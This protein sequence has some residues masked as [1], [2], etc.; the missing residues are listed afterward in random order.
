M[1]KVIVVGASSGIGAELVRLMIERGDR[2]AAVARR[3]DRLEELEG[4]LRFAHDVRRTEEIPAL[5][6]DICGQLGGLDMIVYAAGVMP[7]VGPEEFDTEKDLQMIDVN[8]A[9]AVAWLNQAAI[10]FQN[11]K[12]GT[13][14]GIGSVAG[15]RGRQGQ[16]VYNASKAA[17]KAYLEALRNRL[18]RQGV[19]VVTIKPGPTATEMTA[20]M[21]QS[22]M[23]P[24]RQA[25]ELILKKSPREGEHFLKPTH[26]IIFAIIRNIPSFILRRLKI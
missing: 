1:K 7:E 12:A 15:E 9:G 6:Q 17:F 2:V 3:G 25:A 13:I 20:H 23:M 18:S 5:F 10:R 22:G 21:D 19:K 14:V 8:F 16:P 4:A 11:T 26:A 24:A